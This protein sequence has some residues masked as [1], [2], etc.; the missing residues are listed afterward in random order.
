[1]PGGNIVNKRAR[2]TFFYLKKLFDI[3]KEIFGI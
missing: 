1:M 2:K 3:F